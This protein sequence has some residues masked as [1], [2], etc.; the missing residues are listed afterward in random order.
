MKL[1][2]RL[3]IIFFAVVLLPFILAAMTYF[4]ISG[5]MVW[6]LR[7]TY[8]IKDIPLSA[9]LN[10]SELYT[11]VTNEYITLL[12]DK[13][14]RNSEKQTEF[15]SN[16]EL[17][18]INRQLDQLS[19]FLIIRKGDKIIYVTA[20]FEEDPV[21]QLL[22]DYGSAPKEENATIYYNDIHRVV[23]Q[24]DYTLPD[25]E[26]GTIFI[27]TCVSMIISEVTGWGVLISMIVVLML[28]GILLTSWLNQG[29]IKP[30]LS[31][32]GAM[33]RIEQGDLDTPAKTSEKGEVGVLYDGFEKM[34]KRLKENEEEKLRTEN[35]NRELIRNI[36]HDLKTPITSVK[37]YVE[38]IMDGVADSPEKMEKYIKTIYNKACDMD[39]LIDELTVYSRID[40]NQIPY[41]FHRMNVGDYFSDCAEEVGLDLENKGIVFEYDFQC[42][43]EVEIS[44][45]PEQLK[46]VINNIINNSVK[47]KKEDG[48]KISLKI[49][50]REEKEVLVEIEDNGKGISGKELEKVFERFYRTDASRNSSQG[51]SGIG[52]SIARKV[53]ED[54]GGEIWATGEE[55]VGLT[56]H[57]TIPF[58]REEVKTE[59]VPEEDS[60]NPIARIEKVVGKT[61]GNTVQG[62]RT[63]VEKTMAGI[64]KKTR[65][66][67]YIELTESDIEPAG[68][69]NPENGKMP[70]DTEGLEK[71]LEE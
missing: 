51:G 25:G 23:K 61:V 38:G 44:A 18:D 42:P 17:N 52:L 39:H 49:S 63:G 15:V 31:L 60:K 50:A 20:D 47:Y 66:K 71:T 33:M 46:R 5:S 29:I 43:P 37:G 24:L 70:K 14:T 57:F 62:I 6:G 68:G 16:E 35:A 41:Q 27:I 10:P 2:T 64:E 8:G 13:L 59:E 65:G 53:V 4:I 11:S 9:A 19:S 40:A 22:P 30:M 54:H 34:R 69:G 45:D 28:T 58:F 1:N 12:K 48:S 56:I 3:I 21:L 26:Q 67:E 7:H 32:K 55:G 36:S